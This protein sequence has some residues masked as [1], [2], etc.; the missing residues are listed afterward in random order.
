MQTLF[1]IAL[2]GASGALLRHFSNAAVMH[3]MPGAAFPWGIF[4]INIVG[5]ALMGVMAGLFAHVGEVPPAFKAFLTVGL[6]GG[7]TT[8]SAFSLDAVLM[9]QKGQMAAAALYIGGSVLLSV[10]ALYGG[11]LLVRGL[12]A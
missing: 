3:A 11:M 12:T 5:S 10:A 9:L 4:L 1:A 7:F 2:G 8:F 6:L